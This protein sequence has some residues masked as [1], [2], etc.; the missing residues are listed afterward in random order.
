MVKFR[1]QI[2]LMGVLYLTILWF[3]AQCPEVSSSEITLRFAGNHPINHHCT[4]GMELY[5][6][7]I[8]ERTN[9][10]KVEVYPSGQLFSDK[11]MVKAL[12]AGAVDMGVTHTA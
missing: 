11:D 5:A 8:M 1:K 7:L 9:K 12:P 6:K 2:V 10:V 4:R 3:G